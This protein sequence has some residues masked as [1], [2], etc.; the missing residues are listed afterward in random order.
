MTKDNIRINE[1]REKLKCSDE[2][3]HELIEFMLYLQDSYNDV[4][5]ENPLFSSCCPETAENEV[6]KFLIYQATEI[7]VHENGRYPNEN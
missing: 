5:I 7:F 1:L 2:V 3:K 6:D 4:G